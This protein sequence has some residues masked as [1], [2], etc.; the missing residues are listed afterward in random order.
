MQLI[1][2]FQSKLLLFIVGWQGR[3]S[4]FDLLI[5]H[6]EVKKQLEE[7]MLCRKS[8]GTNAEPPL[9]VRPQQCLCLCPRATT[10]IFQ[11]TEILACVQEPPGAP[12]RCLSQFNQ[13]KHKDREMLELNHMFPWA[14]CLLNAL[15]VWLHNM[16][17]KT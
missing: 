9:T 4:L 16:R 15:R 1:I 11:Q 12:M 2:L 3:M 17:N 7:V 6:R 14:F 8:W 10:V 5:S 13:M